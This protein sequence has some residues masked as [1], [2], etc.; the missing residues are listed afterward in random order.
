MKVYST[1]REVSFLMHSLGLDLGVPVEDIDW[2]KTSIECSGIPATA[3]LLHRYNSNYM[4]CLESK[5]LGQ[6]LRS[7]CEEIPP[8]FLSKFRNTSPTAES[9]NAIRQFCLFLSKVKDVGE[10]IAPSEVLNEFVAYCEKDDNLPELDF[11]NSTLQLAKS[12]IRFILDG[13]DIGYGRFGPGSVNNAEFADRYSSSWRSTDCG[14]RNGLFHNHDHFV[15]SLNRCAPNTHWDF[16]APMRHNRSEFL[17]VPKDIRG[18]RTICRETVESMYHQQGIRRSMEKSITSHP[19]GKGIS[20]ID[21]SQNAQLALTS[22]VTKEFATIDLKDASDRISYSLVS[23]LFKGTAIWDEMIKCRSTQV[24]YGD[25]SHNL[26]K[27]APMGS[28][29]CFTTLALVVHALIKSAFALAGHAGAECYVF[30]DD[31]IVPSSLYLVAVAALEAGGLTVSMTKSFVNSHF[32]ESCGMD[33]YEGVDVTPVRLRYMPTLHSFRL[34]SLA[35]Y[36]STIHQLY[37]KKYYRAAQY[38]TALVCT[39][40]SC[41]G[42]RILPGTL[43]D[44]YL[45]APEALMLPVQYKKRRMVYGVPH[46]VV[47]AIFVED[48]KIQSRETDIDLFYRSVSPGLTP[49]GHVNSVEEPITGKIDYSRTSVRNVRLIARKVNYPIG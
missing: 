36:C 37:H 20:F 18:H 8:G 15:A 47:K 42:G 23:F 27:W 7:G 22:S 39:Y 13:C 4:E 28:A 32:R 2:V 3:L 49:R 34:A 12:R 31:I 40:A 19:L 16:F 43:L 44:P 6:T 17:L 25:A 33:A 26:R 10:K 45:T 41:D 9:I 1:R 24:F 35:S 14:M 21:Q 48:R 38:L 5:T 30:G 11:T 46:A 29:I